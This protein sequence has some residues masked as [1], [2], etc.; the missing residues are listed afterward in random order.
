MMVKALKLLRRSLGAPLVVI[1]APWLV[2]MEPMPP[3][4]MI[5]MG[6]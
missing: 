1:E 2:E 5:Q 4:L 3:S 6:K